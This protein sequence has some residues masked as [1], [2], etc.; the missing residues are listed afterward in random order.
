MTATIKPIIEG[1]K[2]LNGIP[3]Q[4]KRFLSVN[5]ANLDVVE[6]MDIVKELGFKP[7]LVQIPYQTHT[8]VHALLWHGFI[9]DTPPDLEAKFD[10]LATRINADAIRYA[11]GGWV[12]SMP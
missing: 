1:I 6:L 4:G 11:T 9:V 5:L 2:T 3:E 8:E 12:T 7:E 10:E